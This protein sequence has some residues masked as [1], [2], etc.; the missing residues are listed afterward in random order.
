MELFIH[1]EIFGKSHIVRLLTTERSEV[2]PFL[3]A[4]RGEKEESRSDQAERSEGTTNW[5]QGT[6]PK[7][8]DFKGN[9]DIP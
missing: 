1:V 2:V 9:F 7:I 6:V 4:V 3:R 5:G 8:L